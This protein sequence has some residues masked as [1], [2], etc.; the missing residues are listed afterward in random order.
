MKESLFTVGKHDCIIKVVDDK[1]VISFDNGY[2]ISLTAEP[3]IL[4]IPIAEYDLELMKD[5]VFENKT[6]T[7]GF[8]TLNGTN[9]LVNFM[10]EDE[11]E[12]R[13]R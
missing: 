7:C 12:Q 13:R 11:Y 4:E 9:T 5:V 6:F 8:S 1:I 3:D 2:E 10:S